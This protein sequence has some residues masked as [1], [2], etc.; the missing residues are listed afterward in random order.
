MELHLVPKQEVWRGRG[1]PR[2]QVPDQIKRA[3]DAT[4]KTGNVGN[5]TILEGE[6]EEAKELVG[7]LTSYAN[8]IGKRM[9]VQRQDDTIRFEMVDKVKRTKKAA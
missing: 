5:V 1:A 3:A 2:K 6:E 7:L 4:Y 8:S 9:R